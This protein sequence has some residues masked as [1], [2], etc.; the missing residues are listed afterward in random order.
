M[1]A[2]Q[3]T[4]KKKHVTV[5]ILSSVFLNNSISEV[6]TSI[7]SGVISYFYNISRIRIVRSELIGNIALNK[8]SLLGVRNN[9]LLEIKDSIIKNNTKSFERIL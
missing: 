2:I 9:Y 4:D 7:S 3:N 8:P 1:I 6:N 5:D